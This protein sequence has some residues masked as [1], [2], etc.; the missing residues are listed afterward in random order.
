MPP[1]RATLDRCRQQ[2]VSVLE[3]N[4]EG[5]ENLCLPPTVRSTTSLGSES[6]PRCRLS[7]SRRRCVVRSV[8]VTANKRLATVEH[9]LGVLTTPRTE[10][11]DRS[12]ELMKRRR[13]ARFVCFGGSAQLS[14]FWPLRCVTRH[15]GVL[16]HRMTCRPQVVGPQSRTN[17]IRLAV[18]V[19]VVV[20]HVGATGADS[21]RAEET[22]RDLSVPEM[23]AALKMI[24]AQARTN[25]ESIETW[26]GS[27]EFTDKFAIGD[28]PSAGSP[29]GG[30][31]AS[32]TTAGRRYSESAGVID[33]SLD[34]LG[35]RLHVFYQPRDGVDAAT[36]DPPNDRDIPNL[37]KVQAE[38]SAARNLRHSSYH[39][40][41]T[42]EHWLEFDPDGHR[43]QLKEYSPV[44]HLSESG[45]RVAYRRPAE[46][47]ARH[48]RVVDFRTCF[49]S[50]QM[51]YWDVCE[52]YAGTLEGGRGEERQRVASRYTS[53]TEHKGRNGVQYLLTIKFRDSSNAVPDDQLRQSVTTFD[54]AVGFNATSRVRSRAGVL[55]EVQTCEFTKMSG[56]FVP[57]EYQLEVY[58]QE[59]DARG[60]EPGQAPRMTR[61]F[62]LTSATVNKPIDDS[63]FSIDQL[64][65]KYGERLSD[66][67]D[68]RLYVVDEV[69]FVPVEE[70]VYQARLDESRMPEKGV[71]SMDERGDLAKMIAIN[72]GIVILVGSVIFIRKW[73][74]AR[75]NSAE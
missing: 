7:S 36:V 54:S 45:G 39:W 53:M 18:A 35:N 38:Q 19:A 46:E 68:E 4:R 29:T 31:D 15:S 64:G 62:V 33:F 17:M 32:S 48:G 43:G 37:A 1:S 11:S 12:G 73:M 8:S 65:M 51:F 44:E 72:I 59:P 10:S 60:R 20:V 55:E 49:Q 16:P 74:H 52:L 57:S 30:D 23:T 13:T 6:S 26:Q 21:A 66:R 70:F 58:D 5:R 71:V 41:L 67:I 22:V 56:V 28:A 25:Y 75:P 24:A 34:V 61:N 69:K 27:Y 42:A 14:M 63:V 47:F 40:I 2:H 3:E 9:P 50:G